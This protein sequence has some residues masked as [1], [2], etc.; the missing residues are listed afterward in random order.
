[1]KKGV[2]AALAIATALLA[3]PAVQAQTT[4]PSGIYLGGTIGY[5]QYQNTCKGLIVT[6]DDTDT[7]ARGFAGYQ[8]NRNWMLELGAGTFGEA[9]GSGQTNVGPGT[10]KK[11]T[12]GFDLSGIGSVYLTQRLAAFGR[13]GAYMMR[14]T[15]D[16]DIPG[17][18]E[19]HDA[20]T[21]SGFMY[22]A[23]ASYT[24]G[25]LGLRAEWFRYDN[26]GGG[27]T[28]PQGFT[29]NKDELDVFAVSILF[30]F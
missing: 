14:T 19:A 15:F 3:A 21:N 22:G 10:F 26:V 13:L 20:K 9:N 29:D 17:V 24:L 23:G 8:W 1:M 6:C 25:R 16:Q 27:Q 30:R 5:S 4:D 7:A 18:L 2:L 12:Y 11:E 28:G